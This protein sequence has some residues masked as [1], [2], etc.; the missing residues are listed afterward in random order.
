MLAALGTVPVECEVEGVIKGGGICEN[1]RMQEV[2]Q[3]VQ[4]VQ[5]VLQRRPRQHEDVLTAAGTQNSGIKPVSNHCMEKQ[6]PVVP[7]CRQ[8]LSK[9]VSAICRKEPSR[10]NIFQLQPGYINVCATIVRPLAKEIDGGNSLDVAHLLRD[11]CGLILDLVALVQHQV[12]PEDGALHGVPNVSGGHHVICGHCHVK[13]GRICQHLNRQYVA[14][15]QISAAIGL[16]V[17][18]CLTKFGCAC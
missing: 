4:L 13:A 15:H 6:Y 14:Q 17:K 2:E 9:L 11:N 7:P 8:Q 1:V 18:L 16:V 12:A 3:R 10:Q 5:V